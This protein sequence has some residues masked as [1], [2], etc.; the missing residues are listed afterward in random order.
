MQEPFASLRLVVATSVISLVVACSYDW[1]VGPA[2]SSESDSGKDAEVD[3]AAEAD[4]GVDPCGSFVQVMATKRSALDECDPNLAF[5]F[6]QCQIEYV[7]ECGCTRKTQKTIFAGDYESL[8]E[9]F[10]GAGC[11][12]TCTSCPPSSVA[13]DCIASGESGVCQP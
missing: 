1:T 10:E 9:E 2:S 4:T 5:P 7:D 12:A 13:W 8:V 6:G 11:E 3:S